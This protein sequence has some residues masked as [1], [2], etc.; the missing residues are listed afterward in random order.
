[1]W[2]RF[3]Q[4]SKRENLLDYIWIYTHING[5]EVKN[6]AILDKNRI[7]RIVIESSLYH[8]R[9]HEKIEISDMRQVC[10]FSILHEAGDATFSLGRV[11][12]ISHKNK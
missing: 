4:G 1:M 5:W 11:N 10:Q 7:L 9:I 3:F 12:R 6:I 2:H 8:L